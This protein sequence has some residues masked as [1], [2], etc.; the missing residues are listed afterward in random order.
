LSKKTNLFN[1]KNESLD[2][3]YKITIVTENLLSFYKRKLQFLCHKKEVAL[4]KFLMFTHI[5]VWLSHKISVLG[6]KKG[7]VQR[8]AMN[9][10]FVTTI[11]SITVFLQ[12]L[13]FSYIDL[14]EQVTKC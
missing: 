13:Y 11:Q 2:R 3:Q 6:G 10:V 7:A 1:L 5:T 8:Q 14:P 12:L 9:P 4:L